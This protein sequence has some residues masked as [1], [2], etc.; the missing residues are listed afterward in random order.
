MSTEIWVNLE[1]QKRRCRGNEVVTIKVFVTAEQLEWNISRFVAHMIAEHQDELSV[2]WKKNLK[3]DGE[4]QLAKRLCLWY[5]KPEKAG[6]GCTVHLI[7]Q[8]RSTK[9]VILFAHLMSE[10]V[11]V[12]IGLNTKSHLFN[13]WTL[14]PIP[15][16]QKK[17]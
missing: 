3:I 1:F 8:T 15:R 17:K 5:N 11:T 7:E 12:H 14:H 6:G 2:L 13:D 16:I 4:E 10:N 9:E